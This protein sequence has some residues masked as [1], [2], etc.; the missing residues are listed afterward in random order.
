VVAPPNNTPFFP[1]I[2]YRENTR[3]VKCTDADGND[4]Y[5][6]CPEGTEDCCGLAPLPQIDLTTPAENNGNPNGGTKP[7]QETTTLSQIS[8]NWDKTK[9]PYGIVVFNNSKYGY[10]KA[11]NIQEWMKDNKNLNGKSEMP[12]PV[13]IVPVMPKDTARVEKHHAHLI[14][15]EENKGLVRWLV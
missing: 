7:K 6:N 4:Y 13:F 9:Y 3:L 2:V 5:V 14:K 10:D 1:E 15:K 12:V 8:T 11:E